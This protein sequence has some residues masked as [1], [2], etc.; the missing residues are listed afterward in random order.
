MRDLHLY[1][2]L[3]V[4]TLNLTTALANWLT[5]RSRSRA[6][7]QHTNDKEKEGREL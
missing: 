7:G 1:I 4:A 3:A 6:Q 5:A 2:P